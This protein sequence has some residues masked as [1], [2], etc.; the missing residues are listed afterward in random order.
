VYKAE[1]HMKVC[2]HREQR[3]DVPLLS[4]LPCALTK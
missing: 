2:V 3:G 1:Q 4:C